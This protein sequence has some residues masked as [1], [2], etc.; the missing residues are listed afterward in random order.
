MPRRPDPLTPKS[1]SFTASVSQRQ[2][3]LT[4]R[5]PLVWGPMT[6]FLFYAYVN[7]RGSPGP[8][9]CVH[10]QESSWAF[11]LELRYCRDESKLQSE[12]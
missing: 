4:P 9:N 1:G 10:P 3:R 12:Q 6:D 11:A 8:R 2:G 5:E 7:M